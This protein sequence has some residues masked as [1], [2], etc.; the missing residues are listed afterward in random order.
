MSYVFLELCA[1]TCSFLW[2][3]S[4]VVRLSF[5]LHSTSFQIVLDLRRN[6]LD[7]NTSSFSF[8]SQ[9]TLKQSRMSLWWDFVV[10]NVPNCTASLVCI[11]LKPLV[12]M[13]QR[14]ECL[15]TL[16]W[17][18]Q[19]LCRHCVFAVPPVSCIIVC[20]SCELNRTYCSPQCFCNYC[21]CCCC[22]FLFVSATIISSPRELSDA[23]YFLL[24]PRATPR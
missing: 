21:F 22:C 18:H 8:A 5:T 10:V 12:F 11:T 2:S 24:R 13:L 14:T 17:R 19:R 6:R 15:T 9:T 3:A 23:G 16:M 20:W 4:Q 1:T 7:C